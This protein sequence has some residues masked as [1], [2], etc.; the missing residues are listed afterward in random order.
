[1]MDHMSQKHV[2]EGQRQ[3]AGHG[4]TKRDKKPPTCTNGDY[5]RFHRQGRCNFYHPLPPKSQLTH[6]HRQTPSNKG[7]QVPARWQ[8]HKQEQNVQHSYGY[9]PQKPQSWAGPRDTSTTW[10]KH[11]ENCLQGRFCALRNEGGQDFANWEASFWM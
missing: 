10:C 3:R 11:A 2:S 9:Q 1:M 8:H 6:H 5:C 4:V 7:Q